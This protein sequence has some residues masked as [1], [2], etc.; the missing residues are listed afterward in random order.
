MNLPEISVKRPVLTIVLYLAIIVLGI[1]SYMR[2][3][4]DM[5]PEIEPPMISVL[6]TYKG[7]SAQDIEINVSKRIETGLS[8]ISNL[9]KIRSTSIDDVS[10]VTLEFEYGTNL[11]EA[12]ND[13]RNALEMTKANLPD[14]AETP[15]IFKFST[16]MIPVVMLGVTADESYFGL[17]KLIED[18]VANKLK[19]IPGVGTVQTIGGPKRQIVVDINPKKLE[20]YNLSTERIGQIIGAENLNLPAGSIKMGRVEYNVRTLGEFQS[21]KEMEKVV[22]GQQNGKIVYLKDVANV[23]DSLQ[24]NTRDVRMKEKQ[25]LI[26]MIQKQSGAN[27]VD[28]AKAVFAKLETLKKDLPADVKLEKVMDSSE[29]IV[30]SISN[31]SDTILYAFIFVTLV[32]IIFL[33]KWRAALIVLLTIPVSLIGAFVYL[34]FSGNTINIISLSSLAIAIGMVVDDAIVILENT[35]R[36]VERGA[37]PREAAIFGSSEVS[38]AVMASTLTIVAVFLPLVFITGLSGILFK[39]LGFM[40]TITILIS[41]FAAL[42][43]VPMLSARLLKSRK[44]EKPIK[45]KTLKAIDSTLGKM[46]DALDDFYQKTLNWVLDHKGTT[47][48]ISAVIFFASLALIPLVGTE[49]MPK[50]DQGEMTVTMELQSG[51]RLEETSKYVLEVEKIIKKDFPEV[52]FYSGRSGTSTEGFSS[53]LIGQSEGS[54]IA[55]IT[56]R[57]S[58]KV[59]RTRSIFEIAD[60]LRKKIEPIA[61]IKTLTVSTS[62]MDA[63][64]MGGG[65]PIEIDVIGP[66]L[67]QSNKIANQIKDFMANLN[68]TRDVKLNVGDPKPELQVKLSREKL[69]LNGLNTAMVANTLRNNIYGMTASKYRELGDEY[70]IFLKYPPSERTSI[71]Q[72]ENLPISTPMGGIIKLKELGTVSEQYTPTEIKRKNQERV[73]TV[74]SDV[75]GRSLGDVTADIKNY[76]SKLDLPQNTTIE[77]GGQ[78]EQ[79]SDSFKDLGLLLL[80]SIVL[81]Y[82]VMAAQFESFL[83]PFIV[84]FSVPFAF[85]GVILALL[86]T[87]VPLNIMSILGA[88]MLVGIVTKNAIVLVDFTNITRARNIP[89]REAIVYSGRNRLR[90]VLMTTLTTLLGTLPLAMSTG[91][92]SENW[93][94]LGIAT[95]GGLLFSSIITLVLVPVLYSVFETR[96]KQKKEID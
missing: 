83:D 23:R 6:T 33:R 66:D 80:L 59:E 52:Q 64:M 27:T 63:A 19:R 18:K 1:V 46:L 47:I 91:Q 72:I 35:T 37:R 40:V 95:V 20:A 21:A 4:I 44:D 81:V 86:V 16:N 36:H 74:V 32:I 48:I 43:I 85:T 69:A 2:L 79:Q 84:M 93:Q 71:T 82:M 53:I 8:S 58:K 45:N 30:D 67:E 70:D 10:A 92:G 54:N 13:I 41:L 68:G 60:A 17:N 65:S 78:I 38:L 94:P 57:L 73:I 11:D 3:S 42:S 89:L 15:V 22:V 29:T 75:Q 96:I 90:P 50:S 51:T 39:Q 9:K 61:G 88:I 7:A 26:L 28:V 34:Y 62:G 24:E 5:L 14:D 77:Y 55:N 49:F 56:I 12:A 87:G 76:V 31:L 25:G